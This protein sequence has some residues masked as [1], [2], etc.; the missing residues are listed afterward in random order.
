L[1]ALKQHRPL[2]S[3]GLPI[4]NEED[5][6]SQALDS[7]LGQ[8]YENIEVIIS[9]NASIDSTPQI[10]KDYAAR[11][12]RVRYHRNETNI[13]GINNFNRVFELAQGEFFMWAAGH[14]VRHPAQ[15]SSCL[16]VLLEDTAVVLCYSQAVW[17]NDEGQPFEPVHEYL[18]TRGLADK[19]TRLN[20]VLWGLQG[21]FPIY[22][23][24]RTDALKQTS[25]YTNVISPDTSLLIELAMLGKFAYIPEPV[26]K[27]RRARDHGDLR[28]Y[29]AKHF[30][31]GRIGKRP[32]KL[33]WRMM[34]ELSTRV[35]RH[36]DSFPGKALG[37]MF[38]IAGVL[39]K[40]RWMR[41]DLRALK[42]KTSRP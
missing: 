14:D 6:L 18:D 42:R 35:A 37:R 3:I 16:E 22:G 20:F 10:C 27:L 7:L 40:F 39:I 41:V 32:Q 29:V 28:V 5:H 9:D 19:I 15:V 8:D 38:V 13:G 26:F 12:A 25:V 4:Y 30:K 23:V 17:V 2:V 11:D 21:G 36:L 1:T 24:F 33:Y 34:R 31:D